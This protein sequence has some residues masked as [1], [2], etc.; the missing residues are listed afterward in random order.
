MSNF[1]KI[2]ETLEPHARKTRSVKPR[3]SPQDVVGIYAARAR[4]LSWD[5]INTALMDGGEEPYKRVQ[6]LATAVHVSAGAHGIPIQK[7]VTA[8]KKKE[9]VHA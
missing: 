5:Q 7:Q 2:L 6:S 9:L 3:F 8:K 4:G 1:L